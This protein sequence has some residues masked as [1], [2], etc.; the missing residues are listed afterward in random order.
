ML[1]SKGET[2]PVV[3]AKTQTSI[4]AENVQRKE[5][6]QNKLVTIVRRTNEDEDE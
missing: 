2:S 1:G 3:S 6:I 4:Y 5:Q